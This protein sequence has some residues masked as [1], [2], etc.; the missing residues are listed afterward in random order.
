VVGRLGALFAATTVALSVAALAALAPGSPLISR[1]AGA[2]SGHAALV[3]EHGDGSVVTRCVP[4][5]TASVTGQALLES[6]GVAW[7]GQTFG[8]YGV[9]V[10]AL[11]SEPLHYTTCPGQDSYWAIFVSRAGGAWQLS[12]AGISSLA[13]ADGDA[14]GFRYVPS[15][16]TP[17]PPPAPAGVCAGAAQSPT[18]AAQSPTAAVTTRP[19]ATATA[20]S[21]T[22]T[23]HVAPTTFTAAAPTTAA[24]PASIVPAGEA[25]FVAIAGATTGGSPAPSAA[26]AAPGPSPSHGSGVDPGLLIAAVAGGGLGGLALLRLAAGR[27][28]VT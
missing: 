7:S 21:A 19:A 12:G 15:V 8:S 13:L 3:V 6:S 18:A 22:A 24:A 20:A 2:G 16:G 10:C 1:C 14:E 25:S 23:A 26:P 28:R 5:A 27:R 17:A 4:F 9:A 11:D